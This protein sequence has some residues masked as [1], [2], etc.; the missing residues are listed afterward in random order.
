MAY[1]AELDENNVV[2]R[3][4][5]VSNLDAP[6]PA[7]NDPAGNEFLASLG[8][9]GNWVQ[10][11]YNGNIRGHF[12]GIGHTYDSTL[13]VFVSPQ[14]FPSWLMTEDGNWRAPIPQPDDGKGYEWDETTKSWVEHTIVRP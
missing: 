11:S 14:P 8:M 6:D 12:A 7:P 2:M 3:V 5:A 9:A 10:T 1:F 4:V 13:N